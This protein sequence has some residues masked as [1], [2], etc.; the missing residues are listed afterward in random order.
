MEELGESFAGKRGGD[1]RSSGSGM[2]HDS[3]SLASSVVREDGRTVY[4]DQPLPMTPHQL[5]GPRLLA[6]ICPTLHAFLCFQ[7]SFNPHPLTEVTPKHTAKQKNMH[8]SRG[9]CDDPRACY[10]AGDGRRRRR[11]CDNE[12]SDI[13][14][15]PIICS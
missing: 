4:G 7:S 6:P 3:R 12:S 9:E 2:G 1:R 13:Q 14:Q 8:S 15:H 10:S 11:R 5:A